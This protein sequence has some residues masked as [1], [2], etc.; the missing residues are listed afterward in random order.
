MQWFYTSSFSELTRP[1]LD[2]KFT[3]EIHW[4]SMGENKEGTKLRDWIYFVYCSYVQA[5]FF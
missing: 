4:I 3:G 5:L 2:Y 1:V